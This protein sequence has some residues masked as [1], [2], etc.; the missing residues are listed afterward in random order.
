LVILLLFFLFYTLFAGSFFVIWLKRRFNVFIEKKEPSI[1]YSI[2]R[3][4]IIFFSGLCLMF[5]FYFIKIPSVNFS[6]NIVTIL[7]TIPLLIVFSFTGAGFRSTYFTKN[8]AFIRGWFFA[9]IFSLVISLTLNIRPLFPHRHFEYLEIPLS[10]IAAYGI[11]NIFLKYDYESLL[12]K[13]KN[14]LKI[15]TP[16]IS[17]I[18]VKKIHF[19][20]NII[21][22]S[23]IFFLITANAFSVYNLHES[24]GQS[25]EQISAGDYSTIDQWMVENLDKNNTVVASDHRLERIVE[26]AGFNT[27][28]DET[29]HLWSAENIDE[30]VSELY[31]IGKNYSR[32]THIIIDD[33]MFEK[34]VHIG[35]KRKGVLNVIMT[36]DSYNKFKS[37]FFTLLY[38]NESEEI[39]EVNNEPLEWTELYKINWNAVKEHTGSKK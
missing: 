19:N 14:F 38:R 10:I 35:L 24:L 31:G 8:G 1:K 33:T 16:E 3:F 15:K 7:L 12:L 30:C 25:H 37:S 5:T 27:T 29:Y 13:I 26:S 23:F 36:D 20:K 11:R 28:K 17:K 6:L 39:D 21:Y 22:F 18:N 9:I 2:K 32:I 4:L 34:Q